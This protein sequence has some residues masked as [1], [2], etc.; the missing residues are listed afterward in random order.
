VKAD[1]V[2]LGDL[3]AEYASEDDEDDEAVRL[4]KI[5]MPAPKELPG[6]SNPIAE[7]AST[8]VGAPTKV[9]KVTDPEHQYD[10]TR[11]HVHFE[12]VAGAKTYEVWVAPYPD[13]RG[14]LKVGPGWTASGQLIQGLRPEREFYAFVVY[15]D[16]QD[17]L[18]KPSAPFAFTLKDRFGYK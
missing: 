7:L 16:A 1:D 6:L 9:T 13:G 5:R 18:S 15:T 3:Y 14:A 17:K 10:G 8:G 4:S 2:L 11:C 12:P